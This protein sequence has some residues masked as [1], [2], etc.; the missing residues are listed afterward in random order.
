MMAAMGDGGL[1]ESCPESVDRQREGSNAHS[2]EIPE[3]ELDFTGERYVPHIGDRIQHEH[4]HR[5]LFALSFCSGKPVLDIACGEGYGTALLGT[6][7]SAVVGI[8]T[9]EETIAHATAA[10]GS[11][12]VRFLPAEATEVPLPDN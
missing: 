6:V 1:D 4:F 8:D 9:S 2:F 10:Y 7:A 12:T 11:A 5:Y 3:S